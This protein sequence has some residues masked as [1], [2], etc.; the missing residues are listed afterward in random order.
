MSLPKSIDDG[1]D[2]L[3]LMEHLVQLSE[4]S[5]ASPLFGRV[6]RQALTTGH[7]LGGG[8]AFLTADPQF[9]DGRYPGANLTALSCYSP[10]RYTIPPALDAAERVTIPV[11]VVGANEDCINDNEDN[12]YPLFQ[13]TAAACKVYISLNG[14]SHCQF[15]QPDASCEEREAECGS[16]PT[17]TREQQFALTVDYTVLWSRFVFSAPGTPARAEAWSELT[18]VLA[19]DYATGVLDAFEQECENP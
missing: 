13:R 14:G 11:L 10:G 6:A 19:S 17:I 7:S 16:Q 15:L 1:N 5:P 2:M 8:T 3:F 18:A 9:V 12:A 4:N